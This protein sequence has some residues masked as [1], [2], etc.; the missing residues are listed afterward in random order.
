METIRQL[1]PRFVRAIA[2]IAG[3][4]LAIG[5]VGAL[6]LREGL[7]GFV[8]V[9]FFAAIALALLALI[10]V[11]ANGP[12]VPRLL[13]AT[14][15]GV[16]LQDIDLHEATLGDDTAALRRDTERAVPLVVLAACGGVAAVLIAE[17]LLGLAG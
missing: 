11:V 10:P 6:V 13:G 3:L 17:T 5:A 1:A 7:V 8:N 15:G 2:I 9:T 12:L 14:F 4:E 16:I